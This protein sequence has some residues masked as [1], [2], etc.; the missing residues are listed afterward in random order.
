MRVAM[1]AASFNHFDQLEF[2]EKADVPVIDLAYLH[3]QSYGN[4]ALETEILE[5]FLRQSTRM[6][7]ELNEGLKQKQWRD[8]ARTLKGS[9]YSV[10]ALQVAQFAER[11]EHCCPDTNIAGTKKLLQLLEHAVVKVNELI[12]QYLQTAT[13]Q[14][15]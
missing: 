9:A 13:G 10:G 4:V 2:A 7:L 6:L 3:Q 15:H 5:L 12:R 14:P 1:V 11:I 8:Y